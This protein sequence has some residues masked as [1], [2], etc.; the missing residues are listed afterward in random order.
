MRIP[1]AAR[2]HYSSARR[3]RKKTITILN[4]YVDYYIK[5]A[6]SS[7]A[8]AFA[9]HILAGRKIHLPSGSPIIS[10][11]YAFT[12]SS[13]AAR[14]SKVILSPAESTVLP[15]GTKRSPEEDTTSVTTP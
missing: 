5:N 8:V 12:S 3:R 6:P 10:E 14:H 15:S 1:A 9:A 11:R 4:Y 13:E 7:Q 2:A